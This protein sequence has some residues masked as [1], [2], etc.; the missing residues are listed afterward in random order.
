MASL[1]VCLDCSRTVHNTGYIG[2]GQ[3]ILYA[4]YVGDCYL[5]QRLKK[6]RIEC[7]FIPLAAVANEHVS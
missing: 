6:K 5:V 2:R 4:T 3:D 1:D 7:T